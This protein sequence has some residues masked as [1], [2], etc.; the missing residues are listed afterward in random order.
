[1]AHPIDATAQA[2]DCDLDAA[3]GA[4]DGNARGPS[5]GSCSKGETAW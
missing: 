2:H 5:A 4:S 3:L 1:V